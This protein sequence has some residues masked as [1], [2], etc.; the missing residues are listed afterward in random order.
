MARC[1][2]GR[3]SLLAL[4]LW[5]LARPAG[6]QVPDVVVYCDPT[7]SYAIR[8]VGALVTARTSAPVHVF[9][10]PPALMLAQLARQVQN[11][12][13]VT[14]SAW[15]DQAEREGLIQPATRTGTWRDTLVIARPAAGAAENGVFALT[16]PTPAATIDGPAVLAALHLS[17]AHVQGMADTGGVAF[18]LRNGGAWRGL[19]HRTDVRA[20]PALAEVQPVA[21]DAYQPIVYGAALSSM[22]SSPNAQAFLDALR[23][24]EGAKRLQADGLEAVQ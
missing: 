8:D 9:S 7:L 11:D 22:A 17:P 4:L 6:A 10:A 18:L 2:L 3:P 21:S 14:G 15:L 23:S 13:V 16:D 20:D 5:L 24:P 1:R 12:V 19:L